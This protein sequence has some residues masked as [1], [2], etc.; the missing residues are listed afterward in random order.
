MFFLT[1]LLTVLSKAN[2]EIRASSNMLTHRGTEKTMTAA[3][4]FVG[5]K[6]ASS[7]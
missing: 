4:R 5:Q 2:W 3:C 6:E 1:K 7:A